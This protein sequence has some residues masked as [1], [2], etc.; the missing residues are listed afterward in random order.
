[1]GQTGDFWEQPNSWE[2]Q[3]L[4]VTLCYLQ[5]SS[6]GVTEQEST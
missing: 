3:A 4:S 6:P 1:M 2:P 5:G